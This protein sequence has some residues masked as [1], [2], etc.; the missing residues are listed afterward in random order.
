MN[1]IVANRAT[2]ITIQDIARKASVSVG[3]VDRVIHNRVGVSEST[4]SEVLNII[5]L[6]DYQPDI[7]ARA[8]ASR[9]PVKIAAI[10]PGLKSGKPF[11]SIPEKGMDKA[12]TE[13][14][15]FGIQ[16]F[17]YPFDQADPLSFHIQAKKILKSSVDGIILAP[18]FLKEAIL[19]AKSC[20]DLNMPCVYINSLLKSEPYLSFIGQDSFA[21]GKVAARL[22][23]D[24][25]GENDHIA[26]IN[27]DQD[28]EN[29]VHIKERE[30]GFITYSVENL[31]KTRK[32]IFSFTIKKTTTP[33][34]N[35]ELQK[36]FD[37]H[38]I[39]GVFITNSRAYRI[40]HWLKL[41]KKY[42]P[43]LIAFD[44]ID[45]NKTL[46]NK[47]KIRFLLSQ[48]PEE[49]GYRGVMALFN[50]LVL[51]RNVPKNQFLPIDIITAENILY[52]DS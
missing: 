20:K 39:Q 49:Q 52:Y 18:G 46:L 21:S 30:K 5:R 50:H 23:N 14:S 27:I 42:N 40:A 10:Y 32:Q 9:K 8:L 26:V 35:N 45:E 7:L 16:L 38:K 17:K 28:P 6:L 15:H 12:V 3:T 31:G 33:S 47:G 34:I 44:L 36:I 4:R 1:R 11:W 19:L 41:N 22:M 37:K 24:C 13:L 2:K 51:K 48:K 25:L 29:Q 43:V